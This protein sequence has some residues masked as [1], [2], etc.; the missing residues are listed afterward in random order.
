[1]AGFLFTAVPSWTTSRP[2]V[3]RALIAFV[4]LWVAGRISLLFGNVVPYNVGIVI[5]Y[6]FLVML[7]MII[8]RMIIRAK[9]WR[10]LKTLLVAVFA[11]ANICF[12]LRC[13]PAKRAKRLSGLVL[14]PCWGY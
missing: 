1:M 14:P 9:N 2:V 12:I 4:G 5:D 6:A 7:E 13:L 11:I 10:N 3:G 8:G